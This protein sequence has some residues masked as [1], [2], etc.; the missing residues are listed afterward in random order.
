MSLLCASLL[1]SSAST[2]NMPSRYT[3]IN[4]WCFSWAHLVHFV[5]RQRNA[6]FTREWNTPFV[7]GFALTQV[8]Y[9][10]KHP[11]CRTAPFA[12]VCAHKIKI[13]SV[14]NYSSKEGK[15]PL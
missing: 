14:K 7:S 13:Q 15:Q 3:K 10:D 12:A 8:A 11:A 2:L 6:Q 5:V 4:C 9:E 1:F